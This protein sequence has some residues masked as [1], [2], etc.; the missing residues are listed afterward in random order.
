MENSED[1]AIQEQR[2]LQD[3]RENQGE[4][5]W[6]KAVTVTSDRPPTRLADVYASWALTRWQPLLSGR[7]GAYKGQI[8]LP[9]IQRVQQGSRANPQR[10][11]HQVN[12]AHRN[13]FRSRNLQ[14][15]KSRY[16]DSDFASVILR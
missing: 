16:W 15:A 5:Y 12:L 13:G 2:C 7:P 9:A 6:R 1:R 4:K 14:P 8:F 10:N 3:S 11:A